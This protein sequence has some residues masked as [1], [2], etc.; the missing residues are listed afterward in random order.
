MTQQAAW[1]RGAAARLPPGLVHGLGEIAAVHG[2][3]VPLHGRLFAQWLHYAF[4]RDCPFP[5]KAGTIDPQTPVNYKESMGLDTDERTAEEIE[6]FLQAE[7]AQ[8]SPS[9]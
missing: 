1:E 7:A 9:P 2:G 5:H 4:P 8:L 6:Q 3:R